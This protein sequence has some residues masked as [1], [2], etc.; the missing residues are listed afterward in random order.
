MPWA[1]TEAL[2][3]LVVV[4]QFDEMEDTPAR[5]PDPNRSSTRRCAT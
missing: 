4:R 1:A 5:A 2:V 3:S